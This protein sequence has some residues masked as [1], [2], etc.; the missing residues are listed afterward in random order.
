MM[1]IDRD[2]FFPMVRAELFRGRL[3]DGQFEGINRLLNHADDDIDPRWMAYILATVQHETAATMQPIEEFGR[4]AGKPYGE[5]DPETGHIYFGRG[6]VQITWKFN[7]FNMGQRLKLDLV[8]NP[9]LALEPDVAAKILFVG[10]EFGMFTGRKLGDYLN[11][12]KTDWLNARRI[13]NGMD[14]AEL[15]AGYARKYHAA[16]VEEK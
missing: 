15:I 11:H 10:M 14:R 8:N 4:G 13:V 2:R 5:P 1:M 12:M 6:Y 3:T 16:L 9:D 7:Y